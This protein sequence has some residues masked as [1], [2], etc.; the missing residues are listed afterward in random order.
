MTEWESC[1]LDEVCYIK[2]IRYKNGIFY[3]LRTIDL[4]MIT[5][6][7]DSSSDVY[8][9]KSFSMLTELRVHWLILLVRVRLSQRKKCMSWAWHL[10][11]SVGEAHILE[12][13]EVV[14]LQTPPHEQDVT[15]GEFLQGWNQVFLSLRLVA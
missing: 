10:F 11:V 3:I 4:K 2:S 1:F 6:K 9:C 15:Q 7:K 13:W 14:Y 8:H 5:S 12:H